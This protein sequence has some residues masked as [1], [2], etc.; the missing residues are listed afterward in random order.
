MKLQP[1]IFTI[2]DYT[3]FPSFFLLRTFYVRG[4]H[5]KAL[6]GQKLRTC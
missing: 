6:E 1:F 3:F 5:R 4:L 2:P